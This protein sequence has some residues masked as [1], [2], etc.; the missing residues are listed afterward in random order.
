[1]RATL[2]I[3]TLITLGFLFNACSAKTSTKLYQK[4]KHGYVERYKDQLEPNSIAVI[5]TLQMTI[6]LVKGEAYL[7]KYYYPP[8]KQLISK[9]YYKD[10]LCRKADGPTTEWLDNGQVWMEGQHKDGKKTGEWKIYDLNNG[11]LSQSGQYA[12]DKKEGLWLFFNPKGQKIATYHYTANVLN[13]PFELYDHTGKIIRKGQYK[14]GVIIQNQVLDTTQ[15]SGMAEELDFPPYLVYCENKN[16]RKQRN[17]TEQ[18]ISNTIYTK[19]QYP[20][21]SKQ[22]GIEGQ[23]VSSFIIDKDGTLKDLQIHRGVNDDIKKECLRV[24]KKMPPW[25]PAQRNGEAV[26]LRYQ[27]PIMFQLR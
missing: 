23:V 17:C 27:L 18:R 12:D 9:T 7:K 8:T 10:P 3:L 26:S 2:P 21:F 4:Q 14:E 15:N 16:K 24:L 1:M 22:N 25:K 13:G 19:L 11:H 6:E 5:A 20:R